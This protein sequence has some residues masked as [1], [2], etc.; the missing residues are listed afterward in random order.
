MQ[1][2][3]S[4]INPVYCSPAGQSPRIDHEPCVVGESS[5]APRIP[6]RHYRHSLPG[7]TQS[8][9]SG[10]APGHRAR[11][12]TGSAGSS[13]CRSGPGE[14]EASV[15]KSVPSGW[16]NSRSQFAIRSYS[17]T[18]SQH[19]IS[20]LVESAG[21]DV[22]GLGH[23][24]I[25]GITPDTVDIKVGSEEHLLAV[26]RHGDRRFIDSV[27]GPIEVLATPRFPSI[28]GVDDVGSLHSPMPG[29]VL[30]LDV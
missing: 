16:R 5:R 26:A 1:V 20:Y 3:A 4:R 7:T 19:H 11:R 27:E 21:F 2:L 18:H 30:R 6:R 8:E 29:T 15:M 24:T 14:G 17:G 9:F 28:E 12:T 23:V 13:T 10:Y 25:N 22:D